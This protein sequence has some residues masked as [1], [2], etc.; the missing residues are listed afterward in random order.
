MWDERSHVPKPPSVL[1]SIRRNKPMEV[2][3]KN[4]KTA[5]HSTQQ[6]TVSH[7][8]TDIVKMTQSLL[9]RKGSRLECNIYSLYH[10]QL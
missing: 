8:T 3:V 6:T 7:K 4:E 10:V 5:M 2:K 9:S 1:A